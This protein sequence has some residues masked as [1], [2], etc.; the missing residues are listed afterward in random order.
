MAEIVALPA[1][2]GITSPCF[3]GVGR[4]EWIMVEEGVVTM[5]GCP[6]LGA[7]LDTAGDSQVRE[8]SFA[9]ARESDAPVRF[10]SPLQ[11]PDASAQQ[12]A[13]GPADGPPVRY[14]SGPG[15]EETGRSAAAVIAREAATASA[16]VVVVER[17]ASESGGAGIRRGVTDRIV[18]TAATDT[19][20]AN[21]HGDLGN[22]ASILVPVAGG[23][24]TKLTVETA[25]ALARHT[26]SWVELFTVIPENPTPE[27]RSLGEQYLRIAQ[28]SLVGFENFDTW[29]YEHDDPAMAIAEQ[30][31]YY[32]AVVLGA[33][34]KGRLR[35][36]V[37][38]STADS[39]DRSVDI[40]VITAFSG[41]R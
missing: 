5:D 30:S 38:G 8:L 32:D 39:V 41:D 22:L 25:R 9:L 6:V 20:V 17:P 33:P 26:G 34:T 40:P 24:N 1:G 35:R 11:T 14:A 13:S 21:G 23:P 31:N 37:F 28:R 18:A 29:L 36:T 16:G 27:E 2:L 7:L 10:L 3:I 19:I 12:V 4:Y 15:T